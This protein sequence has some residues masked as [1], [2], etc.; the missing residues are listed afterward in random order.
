MK[1]LI[2]LLVLI[3]ALFGAFGATKVS[4]VDLVRGAI[5]EVFQD[6]NSPTGFSCWFQQV[7]PRKFHGK[8]NGG[9]IC[10]RT[11]QET[12]VLHELPYRPPQNNEF[13]L[14][15]ILGGILVFLVG[16]LVVLILPMLRREGDRQATEF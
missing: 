14:E 8:V 9:D 2:G 3:V 7:F 1:K 11:S 5:V 10:L 6:S 4:L 13:S 15:T 12:V 16:I